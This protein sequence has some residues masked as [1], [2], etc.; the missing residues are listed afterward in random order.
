MDVETIDLVGVGIGPFNLGL[1]ALLA[2]HPAVSCRFLDRK[3][4]FSWHGGMMLPGTTLQV[5][6]M[7][8]LVTMA[9]PCHE[10][11]FLNYLHRHDRLYRFYYHERFHILREEYDHYCRWASRRLPSCRFGEEVTSVRHEPASDT[12]LVESRLASGECRRYRGRNLAVG[13]GTTPFVPGWADVRCRAPLIHAADF[14]DWRARLSECR[15]VTVVGSGQSAAECVLELYRALTPEQIAAGASIY[16]ITRSPGFYPMES[17]K[18]GQAC[19]TPDYLRHFHHIPRQRRRHIVAGQGLL[20]K[21]ISV[22]TIA[23]IYDLMYERSVGGREPGLSL[24]ADCEVTSV[25]EPV[26]GRLRLTLRHATLN[27]E[28]QADSD[29]IVAATGYH[30]AW[31]SWF[32]DLKD[33]LLATDDHG[34]AIVDGDFTARRRDGGA[35]RVF[36][37]NAEI[38]QHGVGA[39]DLGLGA[40]RNGVIANQLLGRE[41]YRSPVDSAFQD[42]GVPSF[43]VEQAPSDSSLGFSGLG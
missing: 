40:Y 24:A 33:N 15:R 27:Q 12:F 17:S 25:T 29:A 32:E 38:F 5:P 2:P 39:P 16:W 22:D 26:S 10:L 28:V 1:A 7:A 8:D 6:F 19:F 35:G 11:S 37:Q 41:H 31:P 3:P 9:D 36:I 4:E 23:E 13:I 34:D 21:G 30:H 18:L 42:F 20:Y 14:A 43:A